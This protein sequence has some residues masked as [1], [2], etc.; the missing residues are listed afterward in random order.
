MVATRY[1]LL[2][3]LG[4]L[5]TIMAQQDGEFAGLTMF[6]G[7]DSAFIGIGESH[8]SKPRAIYSEALIIRALEAQG[9]DW[10]D[11]WQYYGNNIQCL[12]TGEQTPYIVTWLPEDFLPSP[13]YIGTCQK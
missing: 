9:M 5:Q 6:D 1:L 3:S 13:R 10:E 4:M 12:Y 7:L 8:T 11:A 2:Y